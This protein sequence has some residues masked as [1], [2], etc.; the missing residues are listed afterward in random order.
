MGAGHSFVFPSMVDL[1]AE[2]LPAERRGL[3]TSLILGAGDLGMLI[4]FM[5][6][7]EVFDRFG[8][9]AGLVALAAVV[10]G[11]TIVF[12]ATRREALRRRGRR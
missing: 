10:L 9:D 3:G 5:S 8:F 6:L 11:A 2:R 4:G 7:G 1:A 12:A